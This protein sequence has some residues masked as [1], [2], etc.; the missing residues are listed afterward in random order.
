MGGFDT[1]RNPGPNKKTAVIA[2]AGS[3]V[4]WR[5]DYDSALRI[6]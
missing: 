2:L 4:F 3:A 6:I 5:S 1:V